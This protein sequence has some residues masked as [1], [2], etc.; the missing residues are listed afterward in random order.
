MELLSRYFMY[1]ALGTEPNN[2]PGC[3]WAGTHSANSMEC[4]KCHIVIVK[5]FK[6]LITLI[7]NMNIDI[8]NTKNTIISVRWR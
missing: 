5:F 7:K 2:F 8:K 3:T 1:L 4:A 6:N